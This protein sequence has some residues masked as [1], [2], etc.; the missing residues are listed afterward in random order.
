MIRFLCLLSWGILLG[1]GFHFAV[2][3]NP[4]GGPLQ[5]VTVRDLGAQRVGEN[6]RARLPAALAARGLR[7][8]TGPSKALKIEVLPWKEVPLYS[9]VPSGL[10]AYGEQ[11]TVEATA[12]VANS[13]RVYR[14]RATVRV[15]PSG[16]PA[17]RIQALNRAAESLGQRLAEALAVALK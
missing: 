14:A 5:P 15:D 13:P 6:L 7:G 1:C 11:F 16:E 2:G 17:S 4:H 8:G 9:S 10:V 12:R 3:E